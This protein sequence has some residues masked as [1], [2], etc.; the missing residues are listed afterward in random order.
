MNNLAGKS[1]SKTF[2]GH[3]DPATSRVAETE[4]AQHRVRPD[5]SPMR[6]R[7]SALLDGAGWSV[8][9]AVALFAFALLF[10]ALEFQSPDIVL[11]TGHHVVS[12][13]QGG[14]VTFRW[15]SEAYTVDVPGYGSGNK[16]DVYFN[17]A[18]PSNAVADN[19]PDR[20]TTGL[21]VGVPVIGGVAVLLAGL[22]R[23][24]RWARRQSRGAASYGSGLDPEFVGRQL[25]ERRGDQ[26]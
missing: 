8:G 18:D 7:L 11:W 26:R 23:K 22:S 5:S 15:H 13:E 6:G 14:L 20:V 19:V 10:L 16:V 1:L 25:K 2:P 17:P 3:P 9:L 21:L 24:R 4:L 12:T